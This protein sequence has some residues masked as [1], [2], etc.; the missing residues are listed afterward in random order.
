[1][2]RFD[3]VSLDEYKLKE[4][5]EGYLEGF[6][7]ATRVG[8]F[9]YMK[10]DG[11]IQKEF[12]PAEE[13]FNQDSIDSFKLKPITDE[14]KGVVSVDNIKEVLI[15]ITG[16]EIKQDNSYLA[17]FVKFT[18]KE[19]ITKIKSGKQGL[20]F[21]YTVELEKQDGMYNGER[22]DYV[23]RNIRGNHLALVFKGRAG[24]KARLRIDSED[25]I[26]VNNNNFN[27]NNE[28]MLR[29]I[30]LDNAEFEVA[31]EVAVKL[32]SSTAK[33]SE[34]ESTNKELKTKMDSVQ[35]EC[36]GLKSQIENFK[37]Q[38][39]AQI[40]EEKVKSKMAL[41]KKAQEIIKNDEDFSNLSER[42]IQCKAIIAVQPEAKF[43]GKSDEYVSARFDATLEFQRADKL[44]QNLKIT[45]SNKDSEEKDDSDFSNESLQAKLI[46]HKG[47]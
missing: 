23:Q 29:K 24:D 6:A 32:D 25:A 47:E 7:I 33:I 21:G 13:V 19:A 43:D 18:D 46:N 12:R 44:A 17:P 27:I 45:A 4:T 15:G 8:V 42:E 11:S 9:S 14:H 5:P 36:D 40:I 16:Q 39:Q 41:I 3:E 37:R 2:Y 38:D 1:M 34:L 10:S 30:K 35:G 28:I 22:Y 20:S 26:C 31:E